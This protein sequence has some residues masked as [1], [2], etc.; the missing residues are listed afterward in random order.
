[1]DFLRLLF[2]WAELRTLGFDAVV[3][4]AIALAGTTIFVLRLGLTMLLGIDGDLDL[5][6]DL[7]GLEHGAG[8]SVLSVLSITAFLM[9]A[10]WMGLVA[11]VD[12]ELGPTAS[13][14]A[15]GGF[16]FALMLMS[17]ALLFYAR[18]MTHEVV[19]DQ[20]DA[21]GRIGTVYMQI[22]GKG[23]GAGQVRVNVQ[24]RSMILPA[25]SNGEALA[26]FSEVRILE[27]RD[28]KTLVVG[29]LDAGGD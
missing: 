1:M 3:Y 11:R 26:S 19:V 24:G 16:G 27:S 7:D 18:K 23:Q 13:A 15:A 21:V 8:F 5:D 14:F 4:A 22:P 12:W 28:D 2:D 20:R 6:G 17:S 10:G 9:G 29:P 25:V